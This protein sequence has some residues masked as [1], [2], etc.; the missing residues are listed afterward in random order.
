MMSIAGLKEVGWG[1]RVRWKMFQAEVTDEVVG[2]SS[3]RC[4]H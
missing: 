1:K 2:R 3:C 4:V